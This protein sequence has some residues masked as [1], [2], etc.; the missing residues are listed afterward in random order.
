MNSKA[1]SVFLGQLPIVTVIALI[2]GLL[3]ARSFVLVLRIAIQSLISTY[4][5]WLYSF[6]LLVPAPES[7]FGV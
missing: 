1:W 2:S 4:I 7:D 3:P 5:F 6:L